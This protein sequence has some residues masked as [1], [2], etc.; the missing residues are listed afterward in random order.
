MSME[1]IQNSRKIINWRGCEIQSMPLIH[2]TGAIQKLCVTAKEFGNKNLQT[3]ALV[4]LLHERQ[5]METI[6]E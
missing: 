1:L 3:I 2:M 4:R 6:Q 5:Q